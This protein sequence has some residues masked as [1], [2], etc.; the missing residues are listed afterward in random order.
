MIYWVQ[1]LERFGFLPHLFGTT[2]HREA[3]IPVEA[4]RYGSVQL[5]WTRIAPK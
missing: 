3:T 4:K 2:W 1:K 5:L